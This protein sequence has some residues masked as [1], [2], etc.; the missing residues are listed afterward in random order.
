MR[1]I[2][3]QCKRVLIWLENPSEADTQAQNE[4]VICELFTE[5]APV[6]NSTDIAIQVH[7]N[8]RQN[9]KAYE[10]FKRYCA[11]SKP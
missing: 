6:L 8:D 2:Y 1:G 3:L 11:G 4:E 9:I 5:F 10:D 7:A